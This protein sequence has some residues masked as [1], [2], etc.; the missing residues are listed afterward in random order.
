MNTAGNDHLSEEEIVAAVV[1]TA[2]LNRLRQR[3]LTECGQC[4]SHV[5]ALTD[6]LA[7]MGRIAESASP[8]VKRPFRAP[9]KAPER[10]RR[11]P[12]GR[13]LAAGLAVAV[14]CIVVGGIFWQ[15]Q[16]TRRQQHVAR[17]MQEAEQLMRQV[18]LLVENPLPQTIMTISAEGLSAHDEDFF[19]FLIPDESREATLSRSATKGL[20]T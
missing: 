16:S 11:L 7:Q 2:D 12:F 5:E 10:N 13:K 19:R 9:S 4:R 18:N 1:D 6:D 15:N 14:A 8:A 17:E 3:H 20:I